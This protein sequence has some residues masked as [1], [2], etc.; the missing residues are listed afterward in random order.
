M[1]T[2]AKDCPQLTLRE[3]L[4]ALIR[5]ILG[6]PAAA[7]PLAI[8]ARLADL[9][10]SSLKMVNLMLSLEVQFDLAIPQADITPENFASIATVEALILRLKGQPDPDSAA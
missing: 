9:G 3:Q 1:S 10:M 5:Q 7:R 6:A 4:I 2:A 8:D